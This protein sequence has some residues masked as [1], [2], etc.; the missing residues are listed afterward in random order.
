MSGWSPFGSQQSSE[1]INVY[2]HCSLRENAI[3]TE[4]SGSKE[5]GGM[6]GQKFD[7]LR[8]SRHF[9]LINFFRLP[10]SGSLSSQPFD[11]HEPTSIR[12]SLQSLQFGIRNSES[13]IQTAPLFRDKF[14]SISVQLKA[15]VQIESKPE[16]SIH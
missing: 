2:A 12:C 14:R 10:S 6:A 4:S 8:S 13:A 3:Q 11:G 1:L 15:I 16:D 9:L 7:L 5:S